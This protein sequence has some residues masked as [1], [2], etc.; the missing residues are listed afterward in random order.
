M[1]LSPDHAAPG[2][3]SLPA[4]IVTFLFTDVEGSTRLWA[5]DVEG[6][7]K[8]FEAH[9]RIVREAIEERGG[10]VFNTGGDSFRAA[11][12]DPVA[13]VSAASAATERLRLHPWD[14]PPLLVR[15]GVHRGRATVRDLGYFGPVP[16]ASARI[17]AIANGGQ[18]LMSEAVRSAVDVETIYMG[19]HR[20]RDI[21]EPMAIHQLGTA[22]HRPL[23]TIDPDLSSLPNVGG[24]IIGRH[25][26]IA[27]IRRLLEFGSLVTLTGIGG[28][29]K[30][31]LAL[32][33]A[34]R[35]LP[36][37]PDGCYFADLT[38]VSDGSELPAALA[39][40]VRLKLSGD[41]PMQQVVDHLAHRQALLLLD[42][43]EH[44]LDDCADFA[45]Q[46]LA[47]SGATILL[48]TTRQRLD[49]EGEQV[50]AVP[51]LPHV[52]SGTELAPA[53]SLFVQ[54][55]QAVNPSFEL[56]TE[57]SP[58]IS[59]ICKSL[60]GLP[61]A[62]ELAGARVSV[63]P[64]EEVL[65]RM[66]DRFRLL[67]GGRGRQ[68]RR[69][70][71]ATLDWS[72]DLLDE[73]EQHFFQQCGAFVGSFDLG[74]A[75]AVAEIDEY[76]AMDLLQSLLAKSLLQTDDTQSADPNR[77]RMLETVRIYAG[78]QLA[79][80][81][82]IGPTRDRHLAHYCERVFA[83]EWAAAGDIGRSIELRVEWANIAS[84]LEWAATNGRWEEAG[85]I[86]FGC[87]GLWEHQIPATE[88]RRWL[89]SI[90]EHLDAALPPTR[91]A[92]ARPGDCDPERE[93]P[94]RNEWLH[95]NRAML[96][97]QLDDFPV[98][99]AEL[100]GLIA[101]GQPEPRAQALA[102]HGFTRLRQF[103][104]ESE[105]LF[106]ECARVIAEHGLG[107][108]HTCALLWGRG[109]HELYEARIPEARAHFADSYRAS[110]E[111]EAEL[112]HVVISGLSLAT[113]EILDGD[114]A[115]AIETLGEYDWSKSVW[116]SSPIVRAL[117][118]VDLGQANEAAELVVAYGRNALRGRLN[119]MSNDA[120]VGLASLAIHRGEN[121][122]AWSL[123]Q[124]ATTPRTPFTIGLAEGLA[125]RI[126]HGAEL[127][128]AHRGRSTPLAM[129]DAASALRAE[130]DR[131]PAPLNA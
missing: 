15:M 106:D 29:G 37:R 83:T 65:A 86:A 130:L 5:S 131:L 31:R 27:E 52:T 114:P 33:V 72:Y 53:I 96:A 13:A 125:D 50:V 115:R 42:N 21:E 74:A 3:P 10:Y 62:I 43:C 95:Y 81:G 100:S 127:R 87:H 77:F 92:T 112:T 22:R 14:G 38:S 93:I 118:L 63:L 121:E 68:R 129:L 30:T 105:E 113:A 108:H 23:R 61:L 48:A 59:E 98:M 128:R 67:S 78:D 88:G 103:Q 12:S 9:D 25:E 32:E 54:R 73:E 1:S 55:A 28:C 41:D 2:P 107:A 56:T 80:S 19:H 4:G 36:G 84:A 126:G 20:L 117:A 85:T 79:R 7:A 58:A 40:A 101:S 110:R 75:A 46:L 57:N 26:E 123:L 104:E 102:L 35:E 8:A 76:E 91:D 64:P 69:T 60:D 99:H 47:R 111:A 17:E 18:V 89:D 109:T 24:P 124:A 45:E 94:D 66:E 116:D 51:S 6:T 70:L 39:T 44:L 49:V 16:N 71:Q 82:G 34:Y 120:L 119:R 11:F 122:R 97:M 90:L